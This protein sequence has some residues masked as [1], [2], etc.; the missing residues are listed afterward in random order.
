MHLVMR[1]VVP[2]EHIMPAGSTMFASA[3]ADGL[4]ANPGSDTGRAWAPFDW[5]RD[6]AGGPAHLPVAAWPPHLFSLAANFVPQAAAIN[7]AVRTGSFGGGTQVN[8]NEVGSVAT[9]E[10]AHLCPTAESLFGGE[11]EAWWRLQAS[12]YAYLYGELARQ[13]AYAVAASQIIGY[14]EGAIDIRGHKARVNFPCVSMV[15]WRD[16]SA[17]ARVW[18]LR[19]FIDVLGNGPKTVFAVDAAGERAPRPRWPLP[20]VVYALGFEL[21]EKPAAEGRV[22]L[23]ANT[24]SS[25][26]SARLAGASGAT[27]HVVDAAAGHGDVPY[28]SEVLASESVA[29]APLAVALVVM[30]R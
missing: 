11:G 22:V 29:L 30:P 3:S 25:A 27:M 4:Y 17:T 1:P 14:P 9:N 10:A 23:L 6:A 24:N 12:L 5:P 28:R 15:D 8:V 21:A 13:G 2:S 16:G 26:A 18:A 7:H 19:M 20:S